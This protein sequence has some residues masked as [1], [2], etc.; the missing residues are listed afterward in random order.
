[1]PEPSYLAR[2]ETGVLQERI[3]QALDLLSECRLCPRR[4]GVDRTRGE[5]GFCATGR[6][7]KMA[8]FGQHFGEEA[9]LVGWNGSGTIFFSSCNLLCTFCQNYDISH[10]GSGKEVFPSDLAS[11]MVSLSRSGVHNINFVTPSHVVPQIL[12]ALP[13]AIEQGLRIPLVFNTGAYDL[14]PTLH[15]LEG[16][17]DLYMPDCKF[18][19]ESYAEKFCSAPDYCDVAR[20]AL[21]EMHRQV[22]DLT[23]GDDGIAIRGLLVRHL[24]MP[25]G[26]AG[27][28]QVMEFLARELS[29]GTYVNVMDQYRPCY[30]AH[31]D[32]LLDRRITREEYLEA[33]ES[34][35]EAGLSRFDGHTSVRIRM[36]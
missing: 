29:K 10:L 7:A 24:V 1:M 6:Y 16:I 34:A 32:P 22:G 27:T 31:D 15:L 13:G 25:G 23:I 3:S 20:E 8:S 2:H 14:V 18:W 26:I 11:A 17:F 36:F 9:P 4:C 35:R 5:T 30:R 19:D 21:K 12:E 28:E 33:V